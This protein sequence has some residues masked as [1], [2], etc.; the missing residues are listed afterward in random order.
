MP[1]IGK[2]VLENLTRG[3]YEDSRVI[4]REYIQNAADQI[5]KALASKA[6]ANEALKIEIDIND[7][8]R[9]IVIADNANGIPK[10][11]VARRLADVADSE[12]IQGED[13]GFRGIGRLGGLAYCRELRFVTSY[14]GES[15]RTTMIWDAARL[16][17]L[18]NDRSVR[19]SAEEILDR[20]IRYEY[21][22]CDEAAHFFR[23]ELIEIKPSNDRLLDA[24]DV[25]A[26]VEEVAPI[27][28]GE[29]FDT[30]APKIYSFLDECK[31]RSA[32][33][34]HCEKFV[35]LHRYEIRLN[36]EKIYRPY[37]T[38]IKRKTKNGRDDEIRDVQTDLI[39]TPDGRVVAW[40]WY[41]ICCFKASIDEKGY[42][43]L[44]GLRLRQFN[45]EIGG[46][47]TLNQFFR[48]PRGNGYFV[49][50][51]HAVDE[52]LIPN[53]RRDYFVENE[54]QRDFEDALRDYIGRNLDKLYHDGSTINSGFNK[55]AELDA[56]ETTYS[57]KKLKGFS[58]P[59]EEET[60]R[61]ELEA[62]RERAEDAVKKIRGIVKRANESPGSPL[63]KMV[64]LVQR[65][66]GDF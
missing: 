8:K 42:N 38:Y 44:V 11:E 64:A 5:D 26:Y 60:L 54:A 27:E 39:R 43:G 40:I 7:R 17:K 9:R 41:G 50:E 49:G 3:M 55:I 23:V 2:N 45:I 63:A 12:K 25:R 28:Y 53:A 1:K 59:K 56:L 51:V 58:S 14:A 19:D 20:I 18:L 36:G 65:E 4:Y 33:P 31:A 48:E 16:E 35:P 37:S 61:A 29:H 13:K 15:E 66:R 32:A 22:P 30:C 34:P 62:Q 24:D 6:F 52:E 47:R 21:E 46:K 10:S 57:Q